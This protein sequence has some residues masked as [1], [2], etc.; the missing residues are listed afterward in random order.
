MSNVLDTF[1]PEMPPFVPRD[2]AM[3]MLAIKLFEI[4]RL[5]LGQA[6]DMAGYSKRGFMDV[7]SHHGVP[8]VDYP[9]SDLAKEIEW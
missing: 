4:G 2:E 8:V 1:V 6:A 7:A 3:L 5:S 9:P